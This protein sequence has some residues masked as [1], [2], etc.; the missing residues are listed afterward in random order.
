MIELKPLEEKLISEKPKHLMKYIL[1]W[2]TSGC[3]KIVIDENE[4]VFIRNQVITITSGQIFYFTGLTHARGMV[5][6]FTY[7]FF[8]KNDND[9][10]LIFH[11]GLFCHFTMNEVITIDDSNS[12]TFSGHLQTIREELLQKPY[13]YVTSIHS[14]IKLLLIGINRNKIKEGE[15]IYKPDATFLKFL[16]LV[17]ANFKN[18]YPVRYFADRLLTTE[19]RL[20]ELSKLHTGKNAQDII[21]GLIVSEAKRIFKYKDLSVKEEAYELGFND[22]FYFSKF[23]KK[24]TRESPKLYKEKAV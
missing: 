24:H 16:E 6:E 9:I 18:N 11:N 2:C 12:K 21:Y 17:R 20:N 13:Q 15:E 22:P 23:F 5:L 14:R 19:S 8:C 10:E 4:F 3:G 1:I 7:D